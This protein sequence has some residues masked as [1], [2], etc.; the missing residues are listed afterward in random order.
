[1]VAITNQT[2]VVATNLLSL[3]VSKFVTKHLYALAE[4]GETKVAMG[5]NLLADI[6]T[7]LTISQVLAI[8]DTTWD[9]AKTLADMAR[10]AKDFTQSAVFV[11]IKL[12][13]KQTSFLYWKK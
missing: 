7:T 2:N 4:T 6:K 10:V 1:M 13:K 11:K 3:G 9:K 8:G 12:H 5:L